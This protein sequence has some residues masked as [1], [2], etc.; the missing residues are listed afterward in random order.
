VHSTKG[1]TNTIKSSTL[2]QKTASYQVL[3]ALGE[4]TIVANETATGSTLISERT[5]ELQNITQELERAVNTT[6]LET[7]LN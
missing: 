2:Q 4:L 6:V 7:V 5:N 3:G 1:L